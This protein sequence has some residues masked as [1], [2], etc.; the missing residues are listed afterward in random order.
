M[1]PQ[2]YPEEADPDAMAE[3]IALGTA[4]LRKKRRREILDG[5]IN[6]Y[7]FD[8]PAELPSWFVDDQKRHF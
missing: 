3:T 2:Q 8:D 1:V 7:V 4:M 6:R 5:S